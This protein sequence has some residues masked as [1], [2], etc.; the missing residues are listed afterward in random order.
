M[1]EAVWAAPFPP[2][3]ARLPKPCP[4]PLIPPPAPNDPKNPDANPEKALPIFIPANAVNAGNI[5]VIAS[6]TA[7]NAFAKPIAVFAKALNAPDSVTPR[8]NSLNLS[9][10]SSNCFIRGVSPLA[11]SPPSPSCAPLWAS[12]NADYAFLNSLIAGINLPT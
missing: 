2:P 4:V 11:T 5:G 7:K 9:L 8:I 10:T 3:E 6:P 1:L 12:S